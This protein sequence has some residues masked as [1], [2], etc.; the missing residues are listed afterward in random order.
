[1]DRD[2][3]GRDLPITPELWE[4]L[5]RADPHCAIA[6]IRTAPMAHFGWPKAR[7]VWIATIR[8]EN[9]PVFEHVQAIHPVFAEAVRGV[10]EAA[11]RQGWLRAP[12][13]GGCGQAVVGGTVAAWPE[14]QPS[15]TSPPPT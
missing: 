15:P 3:Y 7:R 4:R 14:P 9:S 2:A 6:L 10:V 11:E 8:R 12:D 1:M 5:R 13:Q